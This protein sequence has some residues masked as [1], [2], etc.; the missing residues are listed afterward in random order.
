MCVDH[1]C[2][3]V[4]AFYHDD[5]GPRFIGPRSLPR[6]IGEDNLPEPASVTWLGYYVDPV[7]YKQ[8]TEQYGLRYEL[9]GGENARDHNTLDTIWVLGKAA[10]VATPE[11]DPQ[12]PR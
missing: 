11:V 10:T 6:W 9:F 2:S 3:Y 12:A 8:A 5:Y 4:S 7:G 1:S